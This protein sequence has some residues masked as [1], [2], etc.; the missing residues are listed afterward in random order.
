MPG[1]STAT[2]RAKCIGCGYTA[3]AESTEWEKVSHPPFGTMTQCPECGST[4]VHAQ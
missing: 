4:D 3:P 1:D 2:N